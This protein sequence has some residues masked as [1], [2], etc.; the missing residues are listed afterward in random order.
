MHKYSV[1]FLISK[2]SGLDCLKS[3]I[4]SDGRVGQVRVVTFDDTNDDRSAY[5][6]IRHYCENKSIELSIIGSNK[7]FISSIRQYNAD[8]VFVCGWYWII[9]NSVLEHFN[10]QVFGIHHSLLPKYRGFS[11]LVWSMINGD[12]VVGSSLFKISQGIDVGD[13]YFNWSVNTEQKKIGCVLSELESK[14]ASDFGSVFNKVLEGTVLGKAQNHKVATYC[15]RRNV[16]SGL[17]DWT[18]SA[19]NILCFIR[20]QSEPYSGA[21]FELEGSRFVVESAELFSQ[22]IYSKPGQVVMHSDNG[23][24]IGCGDGFGIEINEIRGVKDI[25]KILNNHDLVLGGFK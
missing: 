17:V 7:E 12:E 3:F 1:I 23:V 14:I 8:A 6:S 13:V 15:A 5:S 24:V 9:P 20:A 16:N 22:Q 25:K 10:N 11:P 4:K 21:F 18:Q 2:K 19:A